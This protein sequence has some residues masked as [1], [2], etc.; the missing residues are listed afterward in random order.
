MR[1]LLAPDRF[2][3]ALT[4]VAAARALARGWA[5]GAPDDDLV[6]APMSDGAAG[7]LD[8]VAAARGGTL[9]PATVPGPLGEPVPAAVLHV[10][11]A[12]GGTAYVEADQVLGR[13]LVA[14]PDRRAAA[15]TGTSAGLGALLAAA[16]R[17]GAGRVVV[18]LAAAAVHDAGA[19]LLAGLARALGVGGFP[20]GFDRGGTALATLPPVPAEAVPA[21]RAALGGVDLVLALANDVP[22]LGLH[23]AGALLGQ[24][25]AVGPATAQELERAVGHGAA[26]LERAAADVAVARP[27][28]A[29]AG[30]TGE[31]ARTRLAR[32]EGSGAGGGAAFA[33]RL[34]GARALP[35]AEVVADAVGLAARV[36]EADL[37]VTGTSVL[38]AAALTASVPATVGR[39][40]LVRGVPVV[41][42]AEAVETSRH[43]VAQIGVSGTYALVERRRGR[44]APGP[45]TPVARLEERA[46]RLARTWST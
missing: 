40:A 46:A 38:D 4:A 43:E 5:A 1:V 41:A 28:L 42:V 45:V 13:H 22:L 8:V 7:F 18:G 15:T 23:G 32:Q 29:L 33:L 26:V 2:S 17:T 34:L 11:G 31:P 30:G 36:S 44:P 6:E 39:L 35:G 37:V 16:V 19:G 25:P 9:V 24:D 27:A 21:V 12:G 10:P 20:D 14:E 3:G